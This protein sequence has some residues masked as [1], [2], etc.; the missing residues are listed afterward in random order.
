MQ[1]ELTDVSFALGCGT[2]GKS[3]C[4]CEAKGSMC[5]GRAFGED[6]WFGPASTGV[7]RK[8]GSLLPW[9]HPLS[10]MAWSYHSRCPLPRGV[11][12]DVLHSLGE[13]RI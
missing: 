10:E 9:T 4:W 12:E 6:P 11:P 8:L 5:G 7:E 3:I 1:R 13:P 2:T